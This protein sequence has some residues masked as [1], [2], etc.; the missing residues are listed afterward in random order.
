MTHKNPLNVER[1][2]INSSDSTNGIYLD[3]GTTLIDSS[4]NIDAPVT[5]TNL[6]TSGNT[7]LGDTSADA[8]SVPSTSTFSA[9]VTVGVDG[10]GYDVQLFGDTAGS[11]MLWDES[12]DLLNLVNSDLTVGG[13]V[14]ADLESAVL[15]NIADT[16]LL[17]GTGAGTC[18]YAVM[19]GDATLANTGALTIAADA[20]E[21]TM[22]ADGDGTGGLSVA[23]NGTAVYDF[24]V[25]G[26][27][28]GVITLAST[29]TFPDNAIV[30]LVYVEVLTTCTSA[31]D[32]ATIKI[33][34]PTDGDLTTAI[35]INDA[36]NPWDA[37]LY[38]GDENIT[39]SLLK[40]TAART[41]QMT[42]AGGEA[43]TAGKIVFH[44]S[45]T[46]SQ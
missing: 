17:I 7:T 27:T 6:T 41:L 38:W 31:T 28:A 16:E 42:V 9:P 36:G 34:L 40:T 22:V 15:T 24:A 26:G 8:L 32:A 13:V 23:K 19:S 21:E 25:D 10:T 30:E 45:Y 1:V 14:T 46:V 4:G 39:T 37:G 20:V 11:H 2:V 43:L 5:T 18:N 3:D 33:D 35:A 44:F 12:G 29:C